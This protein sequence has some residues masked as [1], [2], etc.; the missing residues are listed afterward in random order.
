MNGRD[1]RGKS[2]A[3]RYTFTPKMPVLLF[4]YKKPT[5]RWGFQAQSIN[6]F[7]AWVWWTRE[8]SL[9]TF[10]GLSFRSPNFWFNSPTFPT[11]F[12]FFYQVI[13]THQ[14]NTKSA[15]LW[16]WAPHPR[17]Q[18]ILHNCV[19]IYK[20]AVYTFFTY[21]KI[22]EKNHQHQSNLLTPHNLMM[23]IKSRSSSELQLSLIVCLLVYHALLNQF[24]S[25]LFYK[26]ENS[27]KVYTDLLHRLYIWIIQWQ[28]QQDSC[29]N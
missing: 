5:T 19:Y 1:G 29:I 3:Q 7:C 26:G 23:Y 17:P 9:N 24:R 27:S 2:F 4:Y 28:Y 14:L 12:H 8:K 20:S 16:I 21:R 10:S 6:T 11:T 15:G 25:L 18:Y 13:N 22:T